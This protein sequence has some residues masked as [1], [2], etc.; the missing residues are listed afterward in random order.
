MVIAIWNVYWVPMDI[1]F[2]LGNSTSVFFD[3]LTDVLFFLDMIVVFRTSIV[4]QMGEEITSTCQIA[5]TYLRGRFLLDLICSIPF[6]VIALYLVQI[7]NAGN[8]GL[9][10]ILK[11]IR[12]LRLSKII[13]LLNMHRGIRDSVRFFVILIFLFMYVHFVACAWYFVVDMH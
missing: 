11:L 10:S 4:G 3:R 12:V 5:K 9:F 1:A 6:D 7:E 13:M 2:Q 8:L